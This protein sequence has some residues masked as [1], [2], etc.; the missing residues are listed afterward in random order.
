M[1]KVSFDDLISKQYLGEIDVD[2]VGVG[3]V[4]LHQR[5]ACEA[6][7]IINTANELKGD[8]LESFISTVALEMVKGSAPTESEVL[9]FRDNVSAPGISAIYQKGLLF[10][11]P[12][13]ENLEEAE[14]N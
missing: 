2:I 3:V 10:N 8:D 14:K 12:V 13:V 1:Q 11:D 9:K 4:S 7:D 6:T 5:S